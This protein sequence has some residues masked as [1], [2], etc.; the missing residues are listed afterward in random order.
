MG[1]AIYKVTA[2]VWLHPG[3]AGWHFV[4]LPLDVADEVRARSAT[5]ARPFGSVPAQITIGGTTWSTS[6]FPDTQRASYLV[7]V[8]AAV[9]RREGIAEGDTVTLAVALTN[10]R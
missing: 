10:D 2:E 8:K 9:R 3:A 4:T 6:L 5:S 7:P 1:D